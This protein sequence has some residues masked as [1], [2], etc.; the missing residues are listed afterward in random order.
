M[1]LNKMN[2]TIKIDEEEYSIEENED[3]TKYYSTSPG[4]LDT[5]IGCKCGENK[6][7]SAIIHGYSVFLI[8]NKCGYKFEIYNG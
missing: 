7:F 5:K 8:C 4:T 1:E 3:G 2:Q 6:M